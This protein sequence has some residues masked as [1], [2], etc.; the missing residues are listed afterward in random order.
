MRVWLCVYISVCI[1]KTLVIQW[2]LYKL[3]VEDICLFSFTVSQPPIVN[4]SA[5]A[6]SKS[7][8]SWKVWIPY[9]IPF[10]NSMCQITGTFSL[11]RL[12]CHTVNTYQV[13]WHLDAP[14]P[15]GQPGKARGCAGAFRET[16]SD[17][18]LPFLFMPV[19]W[20]RKKGTGSPAVNAGLVVDPLFTSVTNFLRWS[21]R[22][23]GSFSSFF[24]LLL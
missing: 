20:T 19:C 6:D 14:R 1:S 9:R 5:T 17:W 15:S 3:V 4:I 24:S 12:K 10:L 23:I 11:E 16:Q 18:E 22:F 2:W 21:W 13:C 7:L 8:R